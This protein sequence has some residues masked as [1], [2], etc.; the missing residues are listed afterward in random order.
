MTLMRSWFLWLDSGLSL[1][2]ADIILKYCGGGTVPK[3]LIS[4][5]YRGWP[6]A[7]GSGEVHLVLGSGP[8]PYILL[9]RLSIGL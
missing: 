3:R 6:V 8:V 9:A 7:V 4:A 5:G 1:T 2:T